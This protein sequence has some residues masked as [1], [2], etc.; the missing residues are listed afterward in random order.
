MPVPVLGFGFKIP[1][2]IPGGVPGTELGGIE[3]EGVTGEFSPDVDGDLGVNSSGEGSCVGRLLGITPNETEG[4]GT[5]GL[6]P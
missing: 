2:G 3:S 5:G 1:T 4:T 6:S